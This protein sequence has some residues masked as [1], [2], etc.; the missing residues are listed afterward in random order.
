LHQETPGRSNAGERAAQETQN[1][2]FE[3]QRA[4][5]KLRAVLGDAQRAKVLY[6][7]CVCVCGVCVCVCV[8]Y[9]YYV[10]VYVYTYIH[11]YIYNMFICLHCAKAPRRSRRCKARRGAT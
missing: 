10:Y 9:V 4:V 5:Q 11:I 6:D 1:S 7:V 2:E 8:F 3:A